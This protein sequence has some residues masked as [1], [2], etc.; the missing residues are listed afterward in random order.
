MRVTVTFNST[1]C[2][3]K[4]VISITIRMSM[5]EL[6]TVPPLQDALSSPFCA[7]E[8][9]QIQVQIVQVGKTTAQANSNTPKL[10]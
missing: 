10:S 9:E 6:Q 3:S 7:I 2:I 4:Q 5:T 1:S 8:A